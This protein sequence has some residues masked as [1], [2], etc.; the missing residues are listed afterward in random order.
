MSTHRIELPSGH[1][2]VI[3]AADTTLVE[4]YRWFASVG[5]WGVYVVRNRLVS[6]PPG[7]PRK[8]HRLLTGA[9]PGLVVDHRNHDGLDNRRSNLR[10]C[11]TAQN[12]ANAR[13]SAANRSGFKGVSWHKARGKWR[14]YIEVNRQVRHLGLF[15][16]AWAA[17]QAYNAAALE[18][19]GEFAVLNERTS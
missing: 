8:L 9:T 15:D 2:T 14:A 3:D 1:V 4:R 18:A 11:T 6:D 17:A 7:A 10:V 16:D 5:P 12:G 13:R 19:W